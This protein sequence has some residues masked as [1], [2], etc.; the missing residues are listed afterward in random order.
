MGVSE[1]RRISSTTNR[2]RRQTVHRTNRILGESELNERENR[3]SLARY[4]KWLCHTF[5]TDEWEWQYSFSSGG[6]NAPRDYLTRDERHNIRQAAL[7]HGDI[8]NYNS[9][10][11]DE[12]KTWKSYVARVLEKPADSVTPDEWD[13][14]N[15]WKITSLVWTSLDAALRPVEV[16][17]ATTRWVDT[18]NEMLRIPADESSKNRENWI[19][20]ITSRTATALSR[21]LT[22]RDNYERYADTDA[23]WLTTHSNPYCSQSLTRLLKRLC[24]D[25]DIETENRDMSWYSIRHSVGT[26]MTRRKI[27]RRQPRNSAINRC[28]RP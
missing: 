20:S 4:S 19:V 17:D 8:P 25:A 7:K 21:W 3:E 16:G 27:W 1:K 5:D 22:E 28:R 12:R 15:G 26:Y 13:Q 9:V 11:P 14:V 24:D 6:G 2:I 10:T 23:L 18:E